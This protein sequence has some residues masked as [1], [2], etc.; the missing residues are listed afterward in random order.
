MKLNF[1]TRALGVVVVATALLGSYPA[2]AATTA[3][4]VAATSSTAASSQLDDAN[5]EPA[6]PCSGLVLIR[7]GRDIRVSGSVSGFPQGINYGVSATYEANGAFHGYYN[8]SRSGGVN[9]TF[10]SGST[11]VQTF[12]VVISSSDAST[13]YCASSIRK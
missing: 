11:S 13:T 8:A 3:L 10:T 6:P 12:R 7:T 5:R 9:Y 2:Q 4:P 1:A